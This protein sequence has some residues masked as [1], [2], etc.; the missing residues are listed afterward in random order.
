M[1]E[2]TNI[3][4]HPELAPVSCAFTYLLWPRQ[5]GR[6]GELR[7]EDGKEREGRSDKCQCLTQLSSF[8]VGLGILGKGQ[9]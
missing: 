7:G 5:V 2:V 8:Q 1:V 9:K 4:A 6:G 3:L